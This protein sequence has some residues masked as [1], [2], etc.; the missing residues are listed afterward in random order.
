MD[1]GAR[2]K[3]MRMQQRLTQEDIANLCG[4]TKSLLSKIENGRVVP[5]IATL[6]KIAEA[7]GTNIS[8]ILE[9]GQKE[10]V[11]YDKDTLNNER[12]F[13]LTNKGYAIYPLAGNYINK[14]IE[15]ILFSA[16]KGKVRKHVLSHEGEEFIYILEGEMKFRVADTEYYLRKGDSLYFDAMEAHGI[17]SVSN[18]VKYLDIFVK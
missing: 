8:N 4:F 3:K 17:S 12:A 5:S 14:K 10:I 13:T 7:L 1:I 16:K 6:T 9:D 15:P 18:E 11:A 2:I